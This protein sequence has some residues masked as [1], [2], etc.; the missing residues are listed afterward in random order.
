M[1][2][3]EAR[4][5]LL[6]QLDLYR[7]KK[8]E[9]LL[10][11]RPESVELEEV[12]PSGARYYIEIQAFWDQEPKPDLRVRGAVDDGS[13]LRSMSPLCEAFIM[14]PDGTFVGE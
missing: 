10:A 1:N 12:G 9:Q 3:E 2:K 13:L 6:K 8:Y 11:L 5:V 14:R 4:A 7:T